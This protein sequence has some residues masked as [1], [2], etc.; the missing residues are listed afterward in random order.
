[1]YVN[2]Q[3]FCSTLSLLTS[4][5]QQRNSSHLQCQRSINKTG[6]R[7]IWRT[8][9]KSHTRFWLVPKSNWLFVPKSC[10]QSPLRQFR[11]GYATHPA[12]GV[13]NG[14]L[15]QNSWYV[16]CTCTY[17]CQEF[18]SWCLEL[19]LWYQEMN[20]WY[21]LFEFV[22]CRPTFVRLWITD[23]DT[24]LIECSATKVSERSCDHLL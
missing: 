17:R 19:N 4:H 5:Q 24:E 12:A 22:I 13:W 3:I 16:H 10:V 18:N 7:L 20:S 9:R 6:P 21:H 14:V 1:M 23:K 11:Y 15:L 2:G 8:N